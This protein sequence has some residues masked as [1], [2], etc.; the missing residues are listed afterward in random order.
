MELTRAR[1]GTEVTH[2]NVVEVGTHNHPL[3]GEIAPTSDDATDVLG[4]KD[5][6]LQVC[7]D[8]HLTDVDQLPALVGDLPEVLGVLSLDRVEQH[9][10]GIGRHQEDGLVATG[11][12]PAEAKVE[13]TEFSVILDSYA[14]DKKINI[15][16]IVRTATGLGLKEAKDLVQ[17]A[18]KP[19]KEGISKEDAEKLKKELEEG[20]AKATIK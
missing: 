11:A 14:D 4:V 20:G 1:A 19:V 10:P 13:Q 3:V 7:F 16:K 12:A 2:A 9:P 17:A 18:P 8:C 5:L 6:T 15:I